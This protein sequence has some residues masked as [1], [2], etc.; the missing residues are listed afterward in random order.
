MTADTASPPTAITHTVIHEGGGLLPRMGRPTVA[1]FRLLYQ[2]GYR[3][4]RLP[5]SS[6]G[7]LLDLHADGATTL[8]GTPVCPGCGSGHST[9]QGPYRWPCCQL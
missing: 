8:A 6:G 5:D 7:L 2:C 9:D 4:V 3:Q 1:S